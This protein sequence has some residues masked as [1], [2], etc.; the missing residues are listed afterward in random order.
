M[1]ADHITG[2]GWLKNLSG[3]KSLISRVSGAQADILLDENDYIVFGDHK[4]RVLSTPG[5]TN[6]CCS[7]Y[8]SDEADKN[9]RRPSRKINLNAGATL[10]CFPYDCASRNERRQYITVNKVLVM[11]DKK[12]FTLANSEMKGSDGFYT[13][14]L[15]NCPD[16]V[17]F[18]AKAKFSD[19]ILVWCAISEAGVSRPYIGHSIAFTGDAL[20]IRGCGRTDFQEGCPEKL[21]QSVHN[22]IFTLPGD[23]LLYPAH[24]YRGMTV[25]TVDEERRLNPRLRKSLKEFVDL[26]NNLNLSYPQQI[27]KSVLFKL[28]MNFRC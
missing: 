21:Y 6:G 15:E 12:Y 27:G 22:K 10:P 2:T 5:H 28:E 24:D 9:S 26:M 25:T 23:T 13:I 11:D 16:E 1:H 8:C 4:L 19:K 17:K 7:F 3:C 14:N 18:R 20:L